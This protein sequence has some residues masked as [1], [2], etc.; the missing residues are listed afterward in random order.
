MEKR[1][2]KNEKHRSAPDMGA[3]MAAAKARDNKNK[4]KWFLPWHYLRE[5]P[6]VYLIIET[7]LSF[8]T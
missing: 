1:A 3:A 7:A 8:H 5:N 4:K 6:W 2:A